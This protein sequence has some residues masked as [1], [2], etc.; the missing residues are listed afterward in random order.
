[1]KKL[2]SVFIITHII[3]IKNYQYFI[4]L[5]NIR[6]IYKIGCSSFFFMD[7]KIRYQ[8]LGKMISD[9]AFIVIILLKFNIQAVALK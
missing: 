6:S 9:M 1:M 3:T 4:M 2:L 7:L 5:L 8:N